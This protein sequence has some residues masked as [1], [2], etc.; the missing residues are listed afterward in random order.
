MRQ[1]QALGD[2][3]KAPAHLQIRC[4]VAHAG[5]RADAQAPVRQRFDPPHVGQPV[6][7]QQALGMRRSVLHQAEKIGAAGN[8]SQ[9]SV[10]RV[11]RDCPR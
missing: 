1:K 3:G 6:D 11:S 10:H 7:V 9:L 8:E 5:Q 4:D 2:D